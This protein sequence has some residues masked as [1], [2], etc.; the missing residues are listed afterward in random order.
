MKGPVEIEP[1]LMPYSTRR[2]SSS[3]YILTVIKED[4]AFTETE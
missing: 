4:M 1:S 2:T 3:L